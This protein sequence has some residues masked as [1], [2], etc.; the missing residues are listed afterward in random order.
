[1]W[2]NGTANKEQR[3]VKFLKFQ[4]RKGA[5]RGEFKTIMKDLMK[6]TSKES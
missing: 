4:H 6:Q 5:K 2:D 1:M 3:T